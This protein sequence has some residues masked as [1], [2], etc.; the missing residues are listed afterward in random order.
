MSYFSKLSVGLLIGAILSSGTGLQAKRR[1]ANRTVSVGESF[2]IAGDSVGIDPEAKADID[3]PS[4]L[5]LVE[6]AGRLYTFE[7]LKDGKASI[8]F[9]SPA[10]G[11]V[12]NTYIETVTVNPNRL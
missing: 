8:R 4:I 11:G 1:L 5:K 9:P 2:T 7:A 3:N 10:P 6:Q 12:V